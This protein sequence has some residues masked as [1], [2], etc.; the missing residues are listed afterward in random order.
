L[1]RWSF[2]NCIFVR[3]LQLRGARIGWNRRN[4]R[5]QAQFCSSA[6]VRTLPN[7]LGS[8][9]M[10]QTRTR[11]RP[12]S[13]PPSR[14]TAPARPASATPASDDRFFRHLV[15]SLRNGV[16]AITRDGRVAAINAPAY[17]ILGLEP[18]ESDVGRTAADLLASEPELARII[19]R[20]TD[21]GHLPNRA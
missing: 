4:S 20:A 11:R 13:A 18:T 10:T 5:S 6:G 15:T 1:Q 19:A 3:R 12:R 7:E 21:G 9:P 8:D 17:R 2:D 14:R 16:L